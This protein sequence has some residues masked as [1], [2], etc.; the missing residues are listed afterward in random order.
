GAVPA[1]T[2]RPILT[3]G[4]ASHVLATIVQR[5][6]LEPGSMLKGPAIVEQSDTTVLI[7]Q[8]WLCETTVDGSLV[9][10][11]GKNSS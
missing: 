11:H 9:L 7:P 1:S 10:K 3:D 5:A 8:G 4:K 2:Q 6:G